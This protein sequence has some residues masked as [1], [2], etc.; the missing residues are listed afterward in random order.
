[1][2]KIRTRFL[3]IE[4]I[5]KKQKEEA[6]K[7]REEKK[8]QKIRPVG[9]KGGERMVQ[10]EVSEE[11]FKKMEKAKELAQKEV[12]AKEEEKK[13]KIKKKS[14]GKKY[15]EAKAK[16]DKN[17]LYS[18]EEAINLLKKIKYAQFD[19]TVELHLN[20]KEVGIKG[21]V[22]LPYGTGKQKKVAVVDEKLLAD[23]EKGKIDFDV[24]ITHPQYMP[25]LVKYAKILG[26]KGLMPNPKNG[27]ISTNPY[28]T[29]KKFQSGLIRFKTESKFPLIHQPVGKLSFPKENLVAN[30]KAF[31]SA[32][33]KN[34]IEAAFIKSSMSPS[35]K[36]SL[37]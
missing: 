35:I 26:P 27:T 23:L 7:R 19:E 31:I 14:R 9:G 30:V 37:E 3:G 1:M 33:G 16:I 21:E 17:K 8:K 15:L 28:E 6:K 12:T 11:D 10:I 24:L 25:R 5:E 34:K 32:V 2:G 20:V 29:A 36:L 22:E 13:K 18:I 4:E